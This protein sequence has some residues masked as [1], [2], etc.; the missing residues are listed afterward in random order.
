[1]RR[2]NFIVCL[3]FMFLFCSH[4]ASGSN[5]LLW[6][7]LEKG[8]FS[9]GFKTKWALDYSRAY[10]TTFS[11]ETAYTQTK[12]PRP[13]LINIWYPASDSSAKKMTQGEYLNFLSSRPQLVKF[14]KELADY[15]R[16]IIAQE[17]VKKEEK[18]FDDDEKHLFEELLSTPTAAVKNAKEQIGKFP[19]I[20]Y[21]SGLGSSI[22]DNSVL[23][24]FLASYGY[25]VISSAFQEASGDSFN[26]DAGENSRADIRYLIDYA[27]RLPNVDWNKLALMGHSAGAQAVNIFQALGNSAADALVSL[28]TTQDY[29]PLSVNIWKHMT[30]VVLNKY[31]IP[32]MKVP[33]LVVAG[34]TAIFEMFDKLKDSDRYY[35][36]T[37][38]MRHNDYIS[39]GIF[40]RRFAEKLSL[41]KSK[42]T[43]EIKNYQNERRL[44]QL[45]NEAMSWYILNFFDA[46]LKNNPASKNYLPNKYK[47]NPISSLEPNVEVVS[48][49]ITAPSK[50]DLNSGTA[51]TPRQVRLIIAEYGIE[52]TIAV[53]KRFS[54][55]SKT[56]PIYVRSFVL[57]LL[58]EIFDKNKED[59]LTLLKVYEESIPLIRNRIASWFIS[60]GKDYIEEEEYEKAI[61]LFQKTL[62]V[63]AENTEALAMIKELRE[64]INKKE[65]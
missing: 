20:I 9:V 4:N 30:D 52:K 63:D 50:Y 47:N 35:L 49:G 12:A 13:I 51:P 53:I 32:N 46:C 45:G 25:V 48:K 39:Q 44:A 10:N 55:E 57:F 41:I 17:V 7:E 3:L 31:K 11:D 29:R 2:L 37:Q 14:S 21:H 23:C 38:N 61:I 60:R 36:T 28:D 15:E 5:F 24:E 6:G 19:L 34:R 26:I 62:I 16:D 40:H 22:E 56:S 42:N 58:E 59:G 18:E 1:M 27:R 65:K 54:G 8:K 33:T 64:K 43:E